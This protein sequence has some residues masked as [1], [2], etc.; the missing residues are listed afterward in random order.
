M[1]KNIKNKIILISDRVVE[2][3]RENLAQIAL[4]GGSFISLEVVKSL[5]YVNV[6]PS[7]QYLVIG[8]EFVLTTVIFRSLIS[9]KKLVSLTIVLFS[10]AAVASIFEQELIADLAG[11]I[12]FL[13]LLFIVLRGLIAD[14]KIFRKEIQREG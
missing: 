6:I 4:I 12:I 9:D 13:L 10:S 1:F 11:F 3:I 5:P 2:F 14:R 7:Y 8:F